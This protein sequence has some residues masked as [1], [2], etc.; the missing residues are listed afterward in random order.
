MGRDRI[1]TEL[2]RSRII[3]QNLESYGISPLLDRGAAAAAAVG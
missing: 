3:N 1:H 2:N